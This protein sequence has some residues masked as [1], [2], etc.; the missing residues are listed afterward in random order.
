M[1]KNFGDLMKAAKAKMNSGTQRTNK[2]ADGKSVWRILPSLDAEDAGAFYRVFGQHWVKDAA[3]KLQTVVVC[4]D[5]T[6]DKPCAVC[7]AL[8]K[9][10]MSADADTVKLLD[11]SYPKR[12]YLMN[13]V[14]VDGPGADQK[15]HVLE[16]GKKVM[17]GILS[18]ASDLF[19]DEGVMFV[20]AA[21]G[22]DIIINRSGKG[23]TTTYTVSNR[24][25]K[26]SKPVAPAELLARVDLDAFVTEESTTKRQKALDTMA[27]MV[28]SAGM[29][30]SPT[31]SV[32]GLLGGDHTPDFT[33]RGGDIEDADEVVEVAATKRVTEVAV[34]L[35]DASDD[36]ID[37]MI[38]ALGA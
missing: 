14:Y 3:G 26:V 19:A 37:A 29:M 32:A 17:D 22:V 4:D 13:A 23:L 30:A 5:I 9:A 12:T 20:D 31:A 10:K 2:P 36:D 34:S 16:V 33:S 1:S 6:F 7:T 15:T 27:G 28:A 25:Q 21:A 8:T 38:S 35:A 24:S 18:I 11:E